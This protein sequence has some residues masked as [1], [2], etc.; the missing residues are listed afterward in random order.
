MMHGRCP[1][2]LEAIEQ[3]NLDCLMRTDVAAPTSFELCAART[4]PEWV[5]A[6]HHT[7]KWRSGGIDLDLNGHDTDVDWPDVDVLDDNVDEPMPLLMKRVRQAE[8]LR[9][10]NRQNKAGPQTVITAAPPA[11]AGAAV[12]A[13]CGICR[14]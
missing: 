7:Q 11:A 8:R 9:S 13:R 10:R 3:T 12:A 5:H 2:V 4:V 1:R 6:L 14:P